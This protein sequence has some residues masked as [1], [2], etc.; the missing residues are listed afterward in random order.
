MQIERREFLKLIGGFSGGIALWNSGLDQLFDV[1]DEVVERLRRGPGIE[2]W[3]TTVC[4]QCPGGCGIRVRLV[5]GVPVYIKGSR[6][7]PI[8][9]GG[10]CPLGHGAIEVLFNPDRIKTPMSRVGPVGFGRWESLEWEA[11]LERVVNRLS[12]LR[13][14]GKPHQVAFLGSGERG[15][16]REHIGRFMRAYGSPNY[17]QIPSHDRDVAAIRLATGRTQVPAPDLANAR[18]VVSFGCDFLEEGHSPVYYTKLHSRLRA[19]TD[20]A[21]ARF[22]QIGPRMGITAANADRWVPIRP[23]TYGALALGVA[24]VLIREEAYDDRFVREH[25]FGFESWTD[26]TGDRHI[27]FKDLVLAEYYPEKVSEITGAPSGTILEL[28]REIENTRPCVI[29]GGESVLDNTNGTYAQLAVNSL[30]ALLGNFGKTGGLVFPDP[31]PV[32]DL[33]EVETDETASK[34]LA[35]EPI[36]SGLSG[37]FPIAE[38]S[39]DRFAENLTA[40]EPYPVDVLFLYGGNALFQLPGHQSLRMALERIPLVVSFDSFLTE[41]SEFAHLILPEHTFLERWDEISEVPTV[42]FSHVSV[43]QPVIDPLHDTRHAGDVLI[44]IA[45]SLGDG[46]AG[47]FAADSYEALI[48]H[49]L[50]GVYESGRGAIASEG[51]ADAWL[52]Y[53]QQRGWHIGSYSSFETFWK[54]LLD[55]GAWWDPLREDID[56]D[57]L[58]S[59]RSRRYEFF[60]QD[61]KS[62]FEASG[63]ESD[64]FRAVGDEIFLPH[65]ENPPASEEGPLQLISFQTLT[66]RDGFGANQPMLQEMFGLQARCF[67]QTWVEL[68]PATAEVFGLADDEWVWIQSVVGSIRVK[69]RV[70]PGIVPGV[71]AVPFGLGHTS[72]GRYAKGY[73]AN[74]HQIMKALYDPISHRPALQATRAAISRTT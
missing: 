23:G 22:V 31:P 47:S 30:N 61:L 46:V 39:I 14:A 51:V 42:A 72:Y 50:S 67:W 7:H 11:A 32:A 13:N 29:M 65:H 33:P 74:P 36:T 68:S 34:S 49:R 18:L 60:V 37:A 73:G 53:L 64:R 44:S 40:G 52:S 12:D 70:H 2:S 9:Q 41:T 58:F 25:T 20:D 27:G 28:A 8:N 63:R 71:L 24:H 62:Q 26:A 54:E 15:L 55:K 69:T 57:H 19:T 4:G 35:R 38:F 45:R 3:K 21:R 66:N 59:T 43:R 17:F 56:A 16:M 5:D 10:M 48:R 6:N 1:P